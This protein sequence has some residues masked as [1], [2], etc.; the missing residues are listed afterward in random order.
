MEGLKEQPRNR[1][2]LWELGVVSFAGQWG[3]H[4][5]P[6]CDRVFRVQHLDFTRAHGCC[7]PP[8]VGTRNHTGSCSRP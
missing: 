6:V 5:C 2:L 4:H 1:G 3:R 7:F 8:S